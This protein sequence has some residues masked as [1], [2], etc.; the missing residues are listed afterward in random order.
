MCATMSICV[1]LLNDTKV[2]PKVVT[3]PVRGAGD[4]SKGEADTLE[5]IFVVKDTTQEHVAMYLREKA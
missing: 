5:V 1:I 4:L 2:E 3:H